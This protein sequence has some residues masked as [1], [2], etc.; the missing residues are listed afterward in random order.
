MTEVKV[1]NGSTKQESLFIVGLHQCVVVVF[2]F[3]PRLVSAV[4]A[5]CQRFPKCRRGPARAVKFFF[6]FGGGTN[7]LQYI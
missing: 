3:F 7:C 6:F 5:L 1:L 2:R 4:S